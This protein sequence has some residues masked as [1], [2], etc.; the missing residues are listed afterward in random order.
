MKP[1]DNRTACSNS[2]FA[3]TTRSNYKCPKNNC[4]SKKKK[5][6]KKKEEEEERRRSRK[7]RKK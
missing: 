3:V 6:K 4:K 2:F 7:K 1:K 5:K